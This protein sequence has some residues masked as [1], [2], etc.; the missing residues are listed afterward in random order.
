MA[1]A[2]ELRRDMNATPR[3][4]VPLLAVCIPTRNRRAVLEECLAS[5]LP[6][7]EAL[8]IGV[9]VSD[10]GSSDDTWQMLETLKGQYTWIQ[11]MRHTRDIGFRDN[12]TGVVLRARTQYVWPLGDKLVLLPG[13]LEYV[14]GELR[15]LQPDA[16]VVSWPNRIV[17]TGEKT[18]S[19]PQLCLVELG[20]HCTLL[21]ATVLPRQAFIGALHVQPLSKDF[22]HVVALFGYLASLP[23][24][25]VLFSDRTPI[26]TGQITL[27]SRVQS[28]WAGSALEV[29]GRSW[30]DAVMS[31]P[32][33][34]SAGEKLRV[35]RSHSEN[36]GILS[37][38]GLIRLRA[39]GQLTL[40]QLNADK[41]SL[42]AAVSSPWWSAVIVSVVPSWMLLPVLYVHPRRMLRKIRSGLRSLCGR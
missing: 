25:R 33:S 22:S 26:R 4:S 24:P 28:S 9:C 38:K 7:A 13:A 14:V 3:G 40:R 31:L 16:L 5:V 41:V 19:T 6:Q 34:Y 29:W 18:Y 2:A 1:E 11:I 12:L 10:N 37:L 8:G 15:R 42:R 36:T 27:E 20:W 32:A 39:L 30:Y 35:I 21:G 23:A 17:S